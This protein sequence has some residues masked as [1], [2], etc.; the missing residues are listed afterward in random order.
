MKALSLLAG[1]AAC[2][3]STHAFAY[4][5]TGTIPANGHTVEIA[6]HQPLKAGM[7]ITIEPGIYIREENL[8]VRI[9]DDILVTADG[10]KQMTE[11]LPRNVD[12]VEKIMAEARANPLP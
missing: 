8:G 5:I 7:A 3:L 12:E 9:E 4:T 6:L 11:R 2:A 1:I 10:H